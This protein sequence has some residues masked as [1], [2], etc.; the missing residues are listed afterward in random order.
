[1]YPLGHAP[2]DGTRGAT[3]GVGARVGLAVGVGVGGLVTEVVGGDVATLEGLI[4]GALDG[5]AVAQ[6]GTLHGSHRL[7]S[8]VV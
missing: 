5:L 7:S 2:E 4:V 6:S 3:I 1:V 8:S